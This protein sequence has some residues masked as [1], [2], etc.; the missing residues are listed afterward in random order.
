M[1]QLHGTTSGAA[2]RA[3]TWGSCRGSFRGSYI[4]GSSHLQD[5]NLL[6]VGLV[7]GGH[8]G[9]ANL[10]AAPVREHGAGHLPCGARE[11]VAGGVGRDP[12]AGRVGGEPG[13]GRDSLAAAAT[14]AALLLRYGIM[15]DV[16]IVGRDADGGE[17]HGGGRVMQ[18]A[19]EVAV[20][21]ALVH[22]RLLLQNEGGGVREGHG[23]RLMRVCGERMMRGRATKHGSCGIAVL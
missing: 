16:T 19:R 23:F 20:L 21:T 15:E 3:A 6:G 9:A 11:K 7:G 17:G 10:T 12:G 8:Q 2:T 4:K 1:A 5:G 18:V 14:A 13:A 22:I